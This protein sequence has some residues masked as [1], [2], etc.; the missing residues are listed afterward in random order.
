MVLLVNPDSPQN[1]TVVLSSVDNS[2]IRSYVRLCLCFHVQGHVRAR[3]FLA[4]NVIPADN[5]AS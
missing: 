5:E 1:H 2:L 3:T 4:G